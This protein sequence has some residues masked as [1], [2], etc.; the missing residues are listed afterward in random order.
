M[1]LIVTTK[2]LR[3]IR[4]FNKRPGFCLSKSR[5]RF[6]E[7]GLDWNEFIRNGLPEETF[8]A[9]GDPMALA[10]IEHAREMEAADGR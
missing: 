1:T 9:T 6:R 4:G 10:L 7:L 8:A 5:P 3:T 2:H